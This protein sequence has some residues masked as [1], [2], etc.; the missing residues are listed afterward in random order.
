MDTAQLLL[1]SNARQ[2]EPQ[3]IAE[4]MQHELR[5]QGI[6]VCGWKKGTTLHLE[7]MGRSYPTRS[8]VLN[9]IK[10]GLAFLKAEGIEAARV[11]V[12]VEGEDHPRWVDRIGL[13]Q[14]LKNMS[15]LQERQEPQLSPC[16]ALPTEAS[17]RLAGVAFAAMA[18]LLLGFSLSLRAVQPSYAEPGTTGTTPSQRR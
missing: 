8:E 7:L 17:V 6:E 14:K 11:V 3:A 13:C 1:I 4:L 12:Y 9:F 10:N 18:T 16:P 2:G 15:E 5:H